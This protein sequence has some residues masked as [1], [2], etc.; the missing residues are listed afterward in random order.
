M[1]ATW[2]T[3]EACATCGGEWVDREVI[4][5]F[6]GPQLVFMS[7]GN[8]TYLSLASDEDDDRVR[9]LRSKVSD[10]ELLELKLGFTTIRQC[11]LKP[12]VLVVD[13]DHRGNVLSET[14]VKPD[15]LGESDLPGLQSTLPM[16]IVTAHKRVMESL[17][18]KDA[19]NRMAAGK[20]PSHTQL[21]VASSVGA[22]LALCASFIGVLSYAGVIRWM[23]P[24]LR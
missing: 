9:W 15:Q 11:I 24:F 18:Q 17:A 5:E 16:E 3:P 10:Y 6:N 2:K 14:A 20:S 23:A 1:R 19:A 13:T 21:W 8:D 12:E 4:L 22:T 7:R